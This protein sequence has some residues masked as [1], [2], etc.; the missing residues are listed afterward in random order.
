MSTTLELTPV[1]CTR[2]RNRGPCAALRR[3][4]G[5]RGWQKASAQIHG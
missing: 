4:R 2:D 1:L 5:P 3:R